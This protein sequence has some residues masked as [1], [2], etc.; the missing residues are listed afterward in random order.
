[1]ITV[2]SMFLDI[3]KINAQLT[4][5][6]IIQENILGSKNVVIAFFTNIT[7]TK[8]DYCNEY[9]FGHHNNQTVS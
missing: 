9:V 7:I 5:R 3:V 8:Y 2:M 4:E 6:K 1:M